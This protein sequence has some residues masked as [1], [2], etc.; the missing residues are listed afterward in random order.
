MKTKH[1]S[2]NENLSK[3]SDYQNEKKIHSKSIS[4]GV[5]TKK[6]K[7]SS[8]VD[9]FNSPNTLYDLKRKINSD[10]RLAESKKNATSNFFDESSNY[11]TFKKN[12]KQSDSKPL[13]DDTIAC[14]SFMDSKNKHPKINIKNQNYQNL[15]SS[16]TK[17]T[18]NK[19][20][21]CSISESPSIHFDF[22][23][24]QLE[25]ND[26]VF[27]DQSQDEDK[28]PMCSD[29]MFEHDINENPPFF[30]MCL[31]DND[32][33][34]TNCMQDT[35]PFG[36]NNL[37][38]VINS[39]EGIWNSNAIENSLNEFDF[40]LQD[41]ISFEN[42]GINKETS[43]LDD[44]VKYNSFIDFLSGLDFCQQDNVFSENNKIN[45]EIGSSSTN[46][47][48]Y[49]SEYNEYIQ[50][51]INMGRADLFRQ[52]DFDFNNNNI[53][54]QQVDDIFYN[55]YISLCVP[56]TTEILI[57]ESNCDKNKN[58]ESISKSSRHEK[59]QTKQK[60]KQFKLK[61]SFD[62]MIE[63]N[64]YLEEAYC[65]QISTRLNKTFFSCKENKRIKR[66]CPVDYYLLPDS[67]KIFLF[68]TGHEHNHPWKIDLN[69]SN[70]KN[71][72]SEEFSVSNQTSEEFSVS[73]Q[74]SELN[75]TNSFKSFNTMKDAIKYMEDESGELYVKINENMMTFTCNFD[76]SCE[77]SCP[78][79]FDLFS[80][81]V[82]KNISL[83]R[84][85]GEHNHP[86]MLVKNGSY[87]Y[88]RT[89]DSLNEAT[90]SVLR[91]NCWKRTDNQHRQFKKLHYSCSYALAHKFKCPAQ[92]YLKP[93]PETGKTELYR[94]NREHNHSF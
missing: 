71:K 81:P 21:N 9:N 45:N 43:I 77:I 64:K 86:Q 38:E 10:K 36:N 50:H 90:E 92:L 30:D 67:N 37:N 47:D 6:L 65:H 54:F 85:S 75:L 16:R 63:A 20:S 7:K 68:S 76:K 12:V 3:S 60:P 83:F 13:L 29:R 32:N 82:T 19:Q 1:L 25:P 66:N 91:E 34:Y 59:L 35:F 24:Q 14:K 52:T 22:S 93:D 4:E 62:T 15:E 17:Y 70:E 8:T 23:K 11:N 28:I 80:D 78:I 5:N 39:S 94:T 2:E 69:N 44:D 57:S 84:T 56:E 48:A 74:T 46:F 88:I 53:G 41:K 79:R 55:D 33:N 26:Y 42:N 49:S 31:L 89:Y 27:K 72:N 18:E 61:R 51:D 73:N 40:C 58:D 87:N